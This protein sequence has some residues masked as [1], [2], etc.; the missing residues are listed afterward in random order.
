MFCGKVCGEVEQVDWKSPLLAQRAREKWGTRQR[1]FVTSIRHLEVK[2][3]TPS[4]PLRAG[5]NVA[6]YATSGWGTLGT[7][8]TYGV[9]LTHRGCPTHAA[10]LTLRAYWPRTPFFRAAFGGLGPSQT[11]KSM[12][13]KA[14]PAMVNFS[15]PAIATA[16]PVAGT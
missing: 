15:V 14:G 8:L 5:S 11:E 1:C 2:I 3:P 16:V 13:A 6:K 12:S 7:Y 9:C 10:C 4:T